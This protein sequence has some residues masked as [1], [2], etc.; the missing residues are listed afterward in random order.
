ML[1]WVLHGQICMPTSQITN[2][3]SPICLR[4]EGAST[5]EREERTGVEKQSCGASDMALPGPGDLPTPLLTVLPSDTS[6]TQSSQ[7]GE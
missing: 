3:P 2:G 1:L 6:L 7:F 4:R 5:V